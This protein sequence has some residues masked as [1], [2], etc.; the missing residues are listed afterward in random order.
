MNVIVAQVRRELWGNRGNF[1]LMIGILFG[2]IVL[3]SAVFGITVGGGF[4]NLHPTGSAN[5]AG[6]AMLG[7]GIGNFIFLFYVLSLT[8]YLSGAL[9]D[10]RKDGSVMFWRSL[11]VS[12][13]TTVAGKVLTA[14]LVGPLFVWIA[15]ILG[16]LIALLAFATA[17]SAR[18]AAGFTVFASPGALFGTW[19]FFAYALVIQ[20][21]WWLPYYSWFL[22]VSAASP[23]GHPLLWAIIPPVLVGVV[24][25]IISHTSHV[26]QFLGSHLAVSPIFNGWPLLNVGNNMNRSITQSALSSNPLY[27]GAGWVTHFLALPSMWIGVGIGLVLLTL[28]VIARR[29]SAT[30]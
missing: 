16:H 13:T 24:E 2:I 22:F 14:G 19:V 3:A 9:Y 1:Y 8:G 4:T 26:F 15:V 17:A 28:A 20:T 11:P 5:A 10:D 18:G 6:V 27:S 7:L 23:R 12:D 29:Y 30:A 21:L 25:L